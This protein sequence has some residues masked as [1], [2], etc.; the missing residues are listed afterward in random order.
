MTSK[1]KTKRKYFPLFVGV[2]IAIILCLGIAIMI[3]FKTKP[4]MKPVND[5]IDAINSRTDNHLE[6]QYFLM[7]DFCVESKR[8]IDEYLADSYE[9]EERDELLEE[10]Y[11]ECEDEFGDWKLSLEIKSETKLNE[12]AIEEL[13]DYYN[14]EYED[15]FEQFLDTWKDKLDDDDELR[16]LADNFDIS[17]KEAKKYVTAVVEHFSAYENALITEG[18]EIKG[19]FIITTEEDEYKSSTVIFNVVKING[20]WAY[21][22]LAL[23]SKKA[24]YFED[25]D[26]SFE[27]ISRY[28]NYSALLK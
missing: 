12:D 10:S 3:I 2:G 20:D 26:D 28:L 25:C 15:H 4:Y 11:D 5:F 17:E 8:V 13:Q 16:I 24:V 23:D 7:P 6:L 22:G 21:A 1:E 18:Y 14:T 19:R 9:Y 27:F